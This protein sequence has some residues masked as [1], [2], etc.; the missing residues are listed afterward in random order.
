M[1]DTHKRIAELEER[2]EL[3]SYD[4][5]GNRIPYGAGKYDGI[6]CRDVTIRCL[7][8]DIDWLVSQRTAAFEA[9]RRDA[10]KAFE[11]LISAG[12]PTPLEGYGSN[13]SWAISDL[14]RALA[15]MKAERDQLATDYECTLVDRNEL[16]GK[17]IAVSAENLKFAAQ[18]ETARKA[19]GKAESELEHFNP[20]L[21]AECASVLSQLAPNAALGEHDREVDARIDRA[22]IS[23]A[24]FGWNCGDSGNN[25]RLNQ[26]IEAK[27]KLINESR[28]LREFGLG[29]K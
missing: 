27:Q 11:A 12:Y 5:K 19:L 21:A 29:G 18:L 3:H 28:R 13:S 4:L 1:S 22:W 8:E 7:Q 24:K 20:E 23:G 2:L 10:S 9:E 15:Q 26:A 6:A 17:H 25:G 16:M 14:C